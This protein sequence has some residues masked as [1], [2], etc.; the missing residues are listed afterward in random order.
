MGTL[1]A[2]ASASNPLSMSEVVSHFGESGTQGLRNFLR[3]GGVVPSS[4]TTT[5]SVSG[6]G[7]S[8]TTTSG[9]QVTVTSGTQYTVNNDITVWGGSGTGCIS[10]NSPF[11][12]YKTVGDVGNCN[13]YT[14]SGCG[15]IPYGINNTSNF[16]QSAFHFQ[17]AVTARLNAGQN[18]MNFQTRASSTVYTVKFKNNNANSVTLSSSS[19]GGARTISSGSTVT[20]KSNS[21]SASWT[22]SGTTSST[23]S[24]N[25]SIPTSETLTLLDFLGADN[26][27]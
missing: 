1:Q 2:S 19:T 21:S 24:I 25:S 23:T 22:F 4:K 6:S 11:S 15:G 26:G 5:T 3:N 13:V 8:S 16:W 18:N 12:Q 14:S 27:A 20:V 9:I 10:I 17:N 7:S